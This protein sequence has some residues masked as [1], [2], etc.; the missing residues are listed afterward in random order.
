[1]TEASKVITRKERLIEKV[2]YREVQYKTEFGVYRVGKK[3]MIDYKSIIER[4]I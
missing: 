3:Q 4:L 2:E 1:M